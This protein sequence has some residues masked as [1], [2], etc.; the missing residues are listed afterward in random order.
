MCFEIII[1]GRKLYTT[2]LLLAFTAFLSVTP[3]SGPL[4]AG[5]TDEKKKPERESNEE[6]KKLM[7]EIDKHY[8]AA[9]ERMGYYALSNSNWDTLLKAG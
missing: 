5:K 3:F 7:E 6:L 4:Y 8:K 1:S 9:Q 2:I